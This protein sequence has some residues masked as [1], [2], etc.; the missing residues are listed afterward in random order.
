VSLTIS[1][2]KVVTVNGK[3]QLEAKA[4]LLPD[5]Q[6]VRGLTLVPD[7]APDASSQLEEALFAVITYFVRD[8]FDRLRERPHSVLRLS[9]NMIELMRGERVWPSTEPPAIA[10]NEGRVRFLRVLR[11]KSQEV[12]GFVPLPE[13]TEKE[14]F[15]RLFSAAGTAEGQQD[16]IQANPPDAEGMVLGISAP[17]DWRD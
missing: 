1:D 14:R 2:L 16:P 4:L 6:H 5:E 17:I 13:L 3:L 8:A 9:G 11:G 7:G 12:G 15:N 10:G